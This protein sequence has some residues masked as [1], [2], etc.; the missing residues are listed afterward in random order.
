MKRQ[1]L[2]F[3]VN[4][5]DARSL[6][7]Q[8]ADGMRQAIV[9]GH[10]RVGDELPSTREL[11][12]LLGVSHIVTRAALARLADEGYV[13]TRHGLHPT[14]RDRAA[15]QWLGHVVFACPEGDEN[16]AQTVIA[17]V[18]RDRLSEDGYRFTQACLPQTS[19]QRYDFSHLEAALSQSTDLVVTMFARR[20]ILA[21]L[22]RRGV[23]YA[24]FG[25]FEKAPTTAVGGTWLNFNLAAGDFAAACAKR[26]VREVVEF[27]CYA[28][29]DA[30]AALRN[31][32]IGVRRIRVR[33]DESEGAL[34]GVVRC[35]MEVFGRLI[36]RKRLS[37]DTVY[38][39]ADNYLARGALMALSYA[40]LRSPEDVRVATFANRRLGPIYPRALSRMEFDVHHA[41]GVLADAVLNYLGTGRYPSGSV[42]GPVWVDG[43][44]MGGECRQR[45]SQDH[46]RFFHKPTNTRRIRDEH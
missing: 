32:G 44:T 41:G 4:R 8:V 21:H 15:K 14:V 20:H 17:G 22:A 28:E 24:V 33:P 30:E 9:S 6:V 36:E 12:P 3:S 35:G 39:F 1:P 11:V 34:V 7:D 31:V 46:E 10:W 16:Y 40:G 38:F 19:P 27:C 25:E 37:R 2:P 42:V 18:L 43:E 5:N 13:L 23:P 45:L 26:G 29:C